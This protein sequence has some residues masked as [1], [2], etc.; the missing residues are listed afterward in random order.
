MKNAMLRLLACCVIV[1]STAALLR[2]DRAADLRNE[3]VPVG[4]IAYPPHD[5]A[6]NSLGDPSSPSNNGFTPAQLRHAYGYDQLST[7]G[8]GQTIA[9]VDAYGSPTIQA[10]LNTFCAA[11]GIAST[12]VQVYYP[13]GT[14]T[15]D[16]DWA[17]ETSLDVEWAHAI[18]PAAKIALVISKSSSLADLDSAVDYAASLTGVTQVSMS[19]GTGEFP[20]EASSDFHF[21]VSGVVFFAATGDT[22]SD[23]DDALGVSY[24]ASSPNV[25]GVGGTTLTLTGSNWTSETGWADGGGGISA[26]ETVPSFQSG[27]WSGTTRGVPDVASDADP[28]TGV[29]I[30]LTGAGWFQVGGT[31]FACPTWAALSALA[32]S[33]RSQSISPT[34]GIFY[35]L[36]TANYAGYYHDITTGTNGTYNAG[37]GYDLVTGL[38]TPIANQLVV[39]LAGGFSGS[40]VAA[41]AFFPPA[42]TYASAQSV[43]LVSATSGATIRYTTN[44]TT[45][46]ETVGTVYTVPVSI[47]ANATLKAIAYKGGLADSSVISDAYTFASQ[48]AAPTFS[49]A[50]GTYLNSQ[51]VAISTATGGATIRY[52]TDGST[53]TETYGTVYSGPVSISSSGP[54]ALNAIAYESGLL[55][56]PVADGLYTFSPVNVLYNLTNAGNGGIYPFGGVVQYSD[57][58]FYGTTSAGGT[59]GDG[60]VFKVTTAGVWTTLVSFTGLN[61]A[62][63]YAKLVLGSD[64]NFYGT[65][66]AGGS[67]YVSSSNTGDGTVFKITPT[68]TLTTLVSFTGTNGQT[69]YAKLVLGSDGNFYG[70]TTAGGSSNDGTIFNV[71]PTGTL[72]T[73]VL[74]TGSNG[75]SPHGGLVQGSDGNFYGTTH[76]G[77]SNAFGTVFSMTS[78]GNL[79]TLV[80][81]AGTNGEFPDSALIQGSDGNY[82]GTTS[83][84]NS[85]NFGTAFQITSSGALTTLVTFDGDNGADPNGGLV[86]GSDGNFYGTTVYGGSADAGTVYRMTSTGVLA[87]VAT[88][89]GANGAYPYSRLIQASDGNYYGTTEYGGNSDSGVFFQLIPQVAAPVFSPAPGTFGSAQNVTMTTTTSGASIRYTTDGSTPTETNGTLYSGAININPSTATSSNVSPNAV[90]P[91]PGFPGPV[92]TH[93]VTNLQAIAYKSGLQDSPVSAGTFT[94]I[95]TSASP[96]TTPSGG[97]GGAFDDWFLGFLALAGLLR[98]KCRK[99]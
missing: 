65:T 60:T 18:A 83:G 40:Q 92:A 96:L 6:T 63:P 58:S 48:A 78:S 89:T 2:A 79:T 32:N 15:A 11:F 42:G 29:P 43:T 95:I 14:P 50:G 84:D 7:T 87:T 26:V 25:V 39:A 57:G 74:F 59:A 36:A 19:W 27:W 47:S 93:S 52:T 91:P 80:S 1:L 30:F 51:T 54:T 8:S 20:T 62:T 38:G 85:T 33:L 82:Y 3:N 97:G 35:T 46:T 34:P 22:G 23:T 81:F 21:N 17:T 16:S 61:G 13:Q 24:P 73:L 44:G 98:R 53:P 71:T 69:P 49:P 45:P 90:P 94:V 68:G 88:F 75:A 56:S 9:I 37:T 5:F 10:D 55:D 41:P 12:T 31:S 67:T 72:T 28:N 77:G 86:Q 66:T 64:G 70:T 76:G 4:Y 99:S